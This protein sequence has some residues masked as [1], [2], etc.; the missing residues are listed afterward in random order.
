[1]S[2]ER[3]LKAAH[4]AQPKLI[5]QIY[6]AATEPADWQRFLDHLVGV[7]DARSARLLWL[8]RSA[9]RV[10]A[11]FMVNTDPDYQ[12]QYNEYYVNL[13][14]WRPEIRS[15]PPGRLYSSYYDFSQS[16]DDFHRSAFYNEWARPQGIEHGIG[17]TIH[18]GE[19]TIQLLLQR[20]REPGCFKPAEKRFLNGLV[21]HLQQAFALQHQLEQRD[22]VGHAIST[23]SSRS[24]LPFLLLTRDA[25]I[26]YATPRAEA[27]LQIGD[28]CHL[29]TKNGKLHLRDP[30]LDNELQALIQRTIRAACGQWDSPGGKLRLPRRGQRQLDLYI[31]PIHWQGALTSL[32]RQR[33]Y[34][35]LFLH[36]RFEATSLD[37]TLLETHYQL[38]PAE[39]RLA[40]LMVQGLSMTE[41]ARRR[42]ASVHTIRNQ[43]KS[44][45]AKTGA[46]GQADLTH[47]LLT[48]PAL[49]R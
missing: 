41:I 5:Q 23:A 31:V 48:G 14:P 40:N 2:E 8:D 47:L 32:S 44:I 38:T 28:D 37:E 20:T 46:N 7:F 18:H 33:C 21:P 9:T 35:A 34:A 10:R 27:L 22:A 19:T 3:I 39:A 16:Q 17:G 25:T 11:S 36:D 26:A 42:D 13:C 45:Y 15:K 43:A 4:E 30:A 24:P 6:Q 12:R 1:M 49:K 29:Q